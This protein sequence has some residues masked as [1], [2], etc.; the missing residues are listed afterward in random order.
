MKIYMG[1]EIA[2]PGVHDNYWDLK[3]EATREVSDENMPGVQEALRNDD[4]VASMMFA[5]YPH[6]DDGDVYDSSK[7]DPRIEL[8]KTHKIIQQGIA[9]MVNVDIL[10]AVFEESLEDMFG[11]QAMAEAGTL[12]AQK[13]DIRILVAL[14]ED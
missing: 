14:Y 4:D 13:W 11:E 3:A 7:D 2:E 9:W 10:C 5:G 1:L 6:P 12:D 8:A